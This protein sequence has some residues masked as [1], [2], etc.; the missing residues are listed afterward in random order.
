MHAWPVT[1]AVE[2]KV[3]Y[4]V[5]DSQ[6]QGI[7]LVHVQTHFP[8]QLKRNVRMFELTVLGDFSIHVSPKGDAA[9]VV[10]Y[11]MGISLH[12]IILL[13]VTV[14]WLLIIPLLQPPL[15]YHCYY[16]YSY[17]QYNERTGKKRGTGGKRERESN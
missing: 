9:S 11:I 1:T 5:W 13:K 2:H 6:D 7:N 16:C 8:S 12:H 10:E 3:L 14:L 15:L 4:Y 17:S